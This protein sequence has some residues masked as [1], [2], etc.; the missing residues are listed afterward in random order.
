M[1][2]CIDM[3]KFI[4]FFRN[5]EDSIPINSYQMIKKELTQT[6]NSVFDNAGT[7][8]GLIKNWMESYHNGKVDFVWL[9]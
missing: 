9:P 6:N 8:Y 5:K 2:Y 7:T 1:C 4:R 3:R